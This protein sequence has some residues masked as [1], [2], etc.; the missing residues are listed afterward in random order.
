MEGFVNMP[1]CFDESFFGPRRVRGKRGRGAGGKTIVF[2]IFKRNGS[3]YKTHINS[4]EGFRGFAK[5]RFT[6][7]RGMNKATFCLH[8]KERESRY[9]HRDQDVYKVILQI[10]KNKP[11]FQS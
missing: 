3:V 10:I 4:I 7:S 11:L 8:L 9:N 2:G 6:R 1:R 5:T